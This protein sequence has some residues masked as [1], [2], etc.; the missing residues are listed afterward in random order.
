MRTKPRWHFDVVRP[1]DVYL[2]S[3]PRSG[4]TWLRYM[5]TA[6]V[7]GDRV[8]AEAVEAIIPDIHHS[9]PGR[10]PSAGP[11]WVKSH[12]PAWRA[13]EAARI[14]YLV[15][16][17]LEATRSYYRYL[18]LR[19]R[20]RPDEPIGSFL[21]TDDIWPCSWARHVEGWLDQIGSSDPSQAMIVRYEDLRAD[22]VG[23]LSRVAAFLTVEADPQKIRAAMTVASRERMRN[24]EALSGA[25]SLNFVGDGSATEI[26]ESAA[27]EFVTQHAATLERAGY[28]AT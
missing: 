17:G 1:E 10:R 7:R 26:N 20:L 23:E 22:P 15:R 19:G 13:P 3:F 12:T 14:V 9:D 27:M 11:V 21:R 5:L 28:G 6:L 8:D 25:G 4:N 18:V 16:H 24:D 2:V